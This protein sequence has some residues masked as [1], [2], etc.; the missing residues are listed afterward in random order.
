[1]N[2]TK[3]VVIFGAF[4]FDNIGTISTTVKEP[5]DKSDFLQLE[6]DLHKKRRRDSAVHLRPAPW[7][8]VKDAN[9]DEWD[10]LPVTVKLQTVEPKRGFI[11]EEEKSVVKFKDY[12]KLLSGEKDVTEEEIFKRNK[13]QVSYVNS[14]VVN[15]DKINYGDHFDLHQDLGLETLPQYEGV[16][17]PYGYV[18]RAGSVFPI[19]LEDNN[20]GSIN[21]HIKGAPKV[22]YLVHPEDK[23]EFICRLKFKFSN[24]YN[25]CNT[26]HRHKTLFV[27]PVDVLLG[28]KIPVQRIVQKEG[29]TVVTWP[30]TFHWGI[31]LGQNITM[32]VN[33][34]P[35][36][37]EGRQEILAARVCL[38]KCE[39]PTINLNIQRVVQIN[40]IFPCM[41]A[42]E[43]Q[44]MFS[45]PQSVKFHML[46]GH[47]KIIRLE[48]IPHVKCPSCFA[49]VKD[50]K[51][52]QTKCIKPIKVSCNL[53]GKLTDDLKKHFKDCKKCNYCAKPFKREDRARNHIGCAKQ[54]KEDTKITRKKRN[55]PGVNYSEDD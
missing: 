51:K 21:I 26:Y 46:T 20:L 41:N 17:S 32:A 22:W 39:Q 10:N 34:L 9:V 15:K 27:N 55:I 53:C 49:P 54:T 48:E 42:P 33:Y 3:F 43:C 16:N 38:P 47:K 23:E 2:F 37:M 19:H 4:G 44:K 7:Y 14:I 6:L 1:M 31:N 5:S 35:R 12:K 13:Y 25:N 29:D 18:G 36:G 52:H 11:T 40:K 8:K 28:M 24:E 30:G 50:L 45:T